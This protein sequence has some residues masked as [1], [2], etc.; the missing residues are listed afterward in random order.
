MQILIN[1]KTPVLNT[2]RKV[3]ILSCVYYTSLAAPHVQ[4]QE[5]LGARVVR[6][7]HLVCEL[8]IEMDV[9]DSWAPPQGLEFQN[10]TT[11]TKFRTQKSALNSEVSAVW[12][13]KL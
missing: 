11:T 12:P 5:S 2:K 9:R 7:K 3:F 1:Q 4:M 8:T 13:K 6:K 10:C